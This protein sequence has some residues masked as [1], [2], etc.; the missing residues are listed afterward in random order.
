MSIRPTELRLE[1]SS[2]QAVV[3][4]RAVEEADPR[5]R[6]LGLQDRREA[7]RQAR[8][9]DEKGWLA[10]RARV[11][12]GKLETAW[13]FLLRLLRLTVPGRG[14][15]VPALLVALG[16]GL[17]TNALGPHRRIQVLAL[18]LLA[19]LAWNLAVL[20]LLALRA[21]LPLGKRPWRRPALLGVVERLARQAVERLP[22]RKVSEADLL[23]KALGQYFTTWTRT[24]APL[25]AA[26]LRR[27]LHLGALMAIA[28][29]VAGM[30]LRGLVF[31]Y[32]ATWESTFLTGPAVDRLLGFVL[33]PAAAILQ[34]D[35]PPA[36]TLRSPA[37]GDAAP[38]IHVWAMTAALVAGVP[39][40]LLAALDT[41]R[42]ARLRRRLPVTVPEVYL[43]K[44]LA[45]ASAATHRIDVVPYS[46]RP[47]AA[48]TDALRTRLLDV[49]GA[50]SDV[51]LHPPKE[52]GD[53]E[54]DL[55]GGRAW[56]VVMNLAQTPENEVH[57][58]VLKGL[59]RKLPD[60]TALLVVVEGS[61]L[62]ERLP[63]GDAGERRWDERRRSWDRLAQ[64]LGL[65]ALHLDL[66]RDAEDEVVEKLLA[67]VAPR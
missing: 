5:G 1:E 10:R 59:L 60:G 35:L 27:L 26:R 21:V 38:W 39:R 24:E 52:Y 54:V 31:A 55:D 56:I 9:G 45:A 14:L 63:A 7:T 46:Y 36:A 20:A 64:Q 40:L 13:P 4:V 8:T 25:A 42:V 15:L 57:G 32:Q 28:G 37:A 61:V 58:E 48:V 66:R 17:A 19:L 43:T 2:A 67:A 22:P 23:R 34:I 11:L 33:G 12:L 62:R 41:W 50:A 3:L 51:R 18:P 30:Y 65:R 49:F 29:A 44:L 16:V 53:T 47:A 6:L